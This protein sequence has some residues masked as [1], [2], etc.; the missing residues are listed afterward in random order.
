MPRALRVAHGCAR[1]THGLG[2]FRIDVASSDQAH[3]TAPTRETRP[4]NFIECL[5]FNLQLDNTGPAIIFKALYYYILKCITACWHAILRRMDHE[6]WSGASHLAASGR[7]PVI[8]LHINRRSALSLCSLDGQNFHRDRSE[9]IEVDSGPAATASAPRSGPTVAA[10][11]VPVRRSQHVCHSN[12]S[13]RWW[14]CCVGRRTMAW[15]RSPDG[16]ANRWRRILRHPKS[17]QLAHVCDEN[18]S[19]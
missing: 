12:P 16:V 11:R 15:I 8:I 3:I 14:R 1:E 9:I 13:D 5:I 7:V 6:F 18:I 19:D 4:F 2:L 17:H 10:G